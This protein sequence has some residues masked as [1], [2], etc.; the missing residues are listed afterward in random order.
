ML[1]LCCLELVVTTAEI[2]LE[3]V[4]VRIAWWAGD[5]TEN[6]TASLLHDTYEFA[7]DRHR[8]KLVWFSITNRGESGNET[9]VRL[10]TPF[11]TL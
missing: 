7:Y 2:L 9:A 6:L 3:K 5:L 4:A 8:L 10:Q 11:C 1:K